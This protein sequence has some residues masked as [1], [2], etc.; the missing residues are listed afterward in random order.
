MTQTAQTQLMKPSIV[1]S[2][3]VLLLP[4]LPVAGGS[5]SARAGQTDKS[6][7][8]YWIDSEGG[9]STLMVAPAGDSVLVDSGNPA[10]GDSKRIDYVASEVAG[11]K[12]LDHLV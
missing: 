2:I 5:P 9:G 4:F 11:L 6:L 12:K 10:G 7:D 8:V 1:L 3:V